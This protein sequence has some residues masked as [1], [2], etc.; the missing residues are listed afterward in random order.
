MS[1]NIDSPKNGDVKGNNVGTNFWVDNHE[2]IKDY[3]EKDVK[4]LI[5]I[6]TKFN[7]LK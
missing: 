1:L 3:C 4:A 7:S 2:E 6:I 5:D